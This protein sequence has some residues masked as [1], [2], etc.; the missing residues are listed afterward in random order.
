MA[1]DFN[2]L[3]IL[4]HIKN[5]FKKIVFFT[6][7]AGLIVGIVS[8]FL[9]NYFTATTSFYAANPLLA[10]PSPLGSN[11][12]SLLAFGNSNDLDRLFAIGQSQ[13]MAEELIGKFDLATH[14]KID[15]LTA[16]GKNRLLLKFAGN[17]NM[18]KNRFD[19]IELS[20]EDKDPI[21]AAK[22]AN[23]ARDFIGLQAS[24]MIKSSNTYQ[25]VAL[26]SAIVKQEIQAAIY[27]D[28]ILAL[29]KKYDIVKSISQGDFLAEQLVETRGNL[30][31]AKAKANFYSGKPAYR[32]STIKNQA[33]AA[34]F[35]QKLSKI[36]QN[37][38]EYNN[39]FSI[40]YKLEAE[41]NQLAYQTG[42][43][44][45]RIKQYEA[46]DQNDVSSIHTIDIA[47]IPLIKSRP[48]R[49]IYVIMAMALVAMTMTAIA[50]IVES[51][52]YE[53]LRQL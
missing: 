43:D 48:H 26:R 5:W 10:N 12:R 29:K 28:S 40:L 25:M 11:E 47:H 2:L 42:L 44:K 38:D 31:E 19:A 46:L 52:I 21:L 36:N 32:D 51:N 14:Y 50:L 13:G 24:K 39:V 33:N 23:A 9:P 27:S 20:F 22:V 35:A 53:R 18:I 49:S 7:A 16:Q 30:E 34:G 41:Y 8:I 4:S 45:E 6:L 3:N 37:V 17:L 15:T 1:Q